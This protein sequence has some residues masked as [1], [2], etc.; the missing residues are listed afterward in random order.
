[1]IDLKRADISNSLIYLLLSSLKKVYVRA[2]TGSTVPHA[3]SQ[4]IGQLKVSIPKNCSVFSQ[5]IDAI[6]EKIYSLKG[7]LKELNSL[8]SFLL[9]LHF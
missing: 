8:K 9:P 4:Y 5:E 3:N 7:Q 6:F 1:M 2:N